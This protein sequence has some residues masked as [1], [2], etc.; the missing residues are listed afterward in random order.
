MVM[1]IG[2]HCLCS[3]S[4]ASLGFGYDIWH[5]PPLS[6]VSTYACASLAAGRSLRDIGS[7]CCAEKPL[8]LLEELPAYRGPCT[9]AMTMNQHFR[10]SSAAGRCIAGTPL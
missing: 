5:M 9:P 7:P 2:L 8:G 10:C 4:C 3:P 1:D 6:R